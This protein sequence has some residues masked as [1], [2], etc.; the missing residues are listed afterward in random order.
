MFELAIPKRNQ[1]SIRLRLPHTTTSLAHRRNAC[2]AS[3]SVYGIQYGDQ[4]FS[5]GFLAKEKFTLTASKVFDGVKF[6]CGENNQGLF[7]GVAG[8]LGLGRDKLSFPLQTAS[9]YNK[10][11]SYCLPSSASYTGHLT[12]G[13]PELLIK[14]CDSSY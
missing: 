11:F 9:A 8:L 6:G 13:S 2:S 14:R 1:S 7:T 12:F 10:I 4:S 5:V 3:N